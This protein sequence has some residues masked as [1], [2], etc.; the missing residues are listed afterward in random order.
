LLECGIPQAE[1]CGH[2]MARA[3]AVGAPSEL[4]RNRPC[5]AVAL[6]DGRKPKTI[7]VRLTDGETEIGRCTNPRKISYFAG[8][9]SGLSAHLRAVGSCSGSSRQPVQTYRSFP[10]AISSGTAFIGLPH[11]GHTFRTG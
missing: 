4:R 6:R 5:R 1:S 10:S 9:R 11:T 3:D 7:Q 8:G 2:E